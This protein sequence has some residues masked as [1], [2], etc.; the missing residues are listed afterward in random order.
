M[1]A[2]SEWTR[3]SLQLNSFIVAF[4]S[5]KIFKRVYCRRLRTRWLAKE[6]TMKSFIKDCEKFFDGIDNSIIALYALNGLFGKF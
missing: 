2:K 6:V 1:L 5:L 3:F 4:G